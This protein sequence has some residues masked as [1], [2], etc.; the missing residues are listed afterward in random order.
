M[1]LK[2]NNPMWLKGYEDGIALQKA[3]REVASGPIPYDPQVGDVKGVLL[4]LL[5]KLGYDKGYAL[6]ILS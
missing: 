4:A 3:V 5:L 1:T 2:K 6:T